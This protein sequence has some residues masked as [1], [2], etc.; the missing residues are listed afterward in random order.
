MRKTS[1]S[2]WQVRGSPNLAML[3]EAHIECA[4]VLGQR[5][6]VTVTWLNTETREAI[7]RTVHC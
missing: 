2:I 3:I 4:D 5:G 7:H 1:E 6:V